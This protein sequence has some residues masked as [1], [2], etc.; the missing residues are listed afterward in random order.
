MKDRLW[1]RSVNERFDA[2]VA[3]GSLWVAGELRELGVEIGKRALELFAVTR[4]LAGLQLFFDA[5]ARQHQHA[6][7]AARFNLVLRDLLF[8]LAVL[9]RLKF[10]DLTFYCFAFPTPGH[11]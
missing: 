10:L 1:R 9:F 3:G 8:V 5:R 11:G 7:F 4:A 6:P 2:R